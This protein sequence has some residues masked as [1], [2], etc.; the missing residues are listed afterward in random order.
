MIIKMIGLYGLDNTKAYF[1]KIGDGCFEFVNNKEF[2][3]D[4][5]NDETE[6]VM[7]N[8]EWYLKNYNAELMF[9]MKKI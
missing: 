9:V 1:R 2:S 4:L 3:S 6:K 5:S 7:K 8:K